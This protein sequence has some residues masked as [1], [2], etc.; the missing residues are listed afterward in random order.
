MVC[1]PSNNMGAQ[2]KLRNSDGLR[3]P[4]VV[5]LLMLTCGVASAA[6]GQSTAALGKSSLWQLS[7]LMFASLLTPIMHFVLM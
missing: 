5:A 4:L 2:T 3:V 1:L 7:S 6:V